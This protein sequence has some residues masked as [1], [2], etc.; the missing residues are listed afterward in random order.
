MRAAGRLRL[1]SQH[2]SRGIG[3]VSRQAYRA[4]FQGRFGSSTGARQK[5]ADGG[6]R[7]MMMQQFSRAP[8]SADTGGISGQ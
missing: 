6:P 3:T 8:S 4:F 2:Y 5:V 1:G 7:S